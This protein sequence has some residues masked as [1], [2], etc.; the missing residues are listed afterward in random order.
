[1]TESIFVSASGLPTTASVSYY[2]DNV[3]QT[4]ETSS[5]YWMGGISGTLPK[6]LSI[7]GA[8]AGAHV[9]RATATLSD[10]T[11]ITS[12][13]ITLNV[14]PSINAQFSNALSTYANQ[15]TA[16]QTSASTLLANITT[17][18]ASLSATEL[19]TRQAVM[20]M[21]L[22][23]GIDPSIDTNNDESS[24]LTGLAPKS[25][26]APAAPVS[27]SANLS[28]AFSPDAPYYHSIP[29]SW[30]KVALP[31]GYIQQLQLNAA[32]GGDGIGYGQTVASSTDPQ[33]TVTSEWYSEQST[34]KT[35][36][37]RMK[38]DWT[39]SLPSLPAGDMHVIF[40]DPSTNSFVSTYKTS[41]NQ[42]TGGPNALYASSPTSVNSLGD[43]GGSTASKFA[44]LPVMI[45]PGEVTN[46]TTPI[47]H[48]IGGPVER[49]WGARVYPA[50]ARDAGM[51]TSK[52]SC[53]NSGYTNT[54][55][56]PY[57]GVIQ[58][59]PKLDLTKLTLSLPA[60]RILQAMQ[61]YGYYVMDF[62]CGDMDI[63]TAITESE[64][65]PYGGM[66]GN[67]NGPGVQNEV[68]RVISTNELY[69]V[70]PL[71]KKQ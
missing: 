52:N 10:G 32:H 56:V 53:T 17:A 21:Y 36:P 15:P 34:L 71:T 41:L 44:E 60:L 59:D 19:S 1:M 50:S 61:T 51:L 2:I 16:Q 43:A 23:W 26:Q 28:M 14:V 48:A 57:G 67:V 20:A 45:Q 22:N 38:K 8:G 25:W 29:S 18:G 9:L 30:P 46:P 3:L 12:N 4:T 65:E 42:Q 55:L 49:T 7:N 6:G 54:G 13:D 11:T 5:P 66:Y 35:F 24:V 69:V 64:V 33:L 37:F 58:L 47:R 39:T 62:G 40:I 27:A 63:Y 70:A 31:S 68:Q